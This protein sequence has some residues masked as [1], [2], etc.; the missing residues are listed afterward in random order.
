[1]N[2]IGNVRAMHSRRSYINS[3]AYSRGQADGIQVGI[4][5]GI[6]GGS[7]RQIIK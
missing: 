2:E 6:S 5:R 4:N 1:M 7:S 3:D